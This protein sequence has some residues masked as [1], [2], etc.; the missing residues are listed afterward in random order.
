MAERHLVVRHEINWRNL[1]HP[2]AAIC[3]ALAPSGSFYI[4]NSAHGQLVQRAPTDFGILRRLNGH[5]MTVAD[6][7]VLSDE[8]AGSCSADGTTRV[9]DLTTGRQV[10]AIRH[11]AG[12]TLVRR[13]SE[14]RGL[15][16]LSDGSA[17]VWEAGTGNLVW[18]R[19]ICQGLPTGAATVEG[20]SAG[21]IL[22][23]RGEIVRVNLDNGE[24][25]VVRRPAP[26]VMETAAALAANRT[27]QRLAYCIRTSE[28]VLERVITTSGE[29]VAELTLGNDLCRCSIW[30]NNKDFALGLDDGTVIVVGLDEEQGLRRV[31]ER[32]VHRNIVWTIDYAV[33]A[34]ELITGSSDGTVIRVSVEGLREKA[35]F[36][37]LTRGVWTTAWHPNGNRLLSAAGDG[38]VALWDVTSSERLAHAQLAGGWIRFVSWT[39][40]SEAIAVAQ[41]GVVYAINTDLQENAVIELELLGNIW[42]ADFDRKKERLCFGTDRGEVGVLELV[43]GTTSFMRL[44]DRL[45]SAVSWKSDGAIIVGTATGEGFELTEEGDGSWSA[46]VIQALDGQDEITAIMTMPDL[47]VALGFFSGRISILNVDGSLS[48]YGRHDGPVQA[49]T[50]VQGMLASCGADGDVNVWDREGQSRLSRHSVLV[51]AAGLSISGRQVALGSGGVWVFD[52]QFSSETPGDESVS[53]SDPPLGLVDAPVREDTIGRKGLV[54]EL[55]FLCRRTSDELVRHADA[56]PLEERGFLIHIGGEWGAGKTSLAQMVLDQLADDQRG[57]SWVSGSFNAWQHEQSS[58]LTGLLAE[59]DRCSVA[60]KPVLSRLWGVLRRFWITRPGLAR[61]VIACIV[62][63]AVVGYALRAFLNL[64]IVAPAHSTHGGLTFDADHLAALLT[65]GGAVLAVGSF[66]IGRARLLISGI[67][68]DELNSEAN[69]VSSYQHSVLRRM[70]KRAVLVVDEVDRC[71]PERVVE[72]LRACNQLMLARPTRSGRQRRGRDSH[73]YTLAFILLSEREWLYNAIESSYPSQLATW[74]SNTKRLGSYFMEKLALV[75]FDL[76]TLSNSARAAIVGSATGEDAVTMKTPGF[77]VAIGFE[78]SLRHTGRGTQAGDG[79]VSEIEAAAAGAGDQEDNVVNAG[80]LRP[81]LS[82]TGDPKNRELVER[83]AE[84]ERRMRLERK[85]IAQYSSL[86]GRNP[87][88]IKRVLVRYWLDRVMAAAETREVNQFAETILFESIVT[89]RW[90]NLYPAI[91]RRRVGGVR[92]LLDQL[93]GDNDEDLHILIAVLDHAWQKERKKSIDKSVVRGKQD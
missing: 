40:P 49:F 14:K 21:Y 85:Y 13:V 71:E 86:I 76:P 63:L 67:T 27:A 53:L 50:V 91:T 65:V 59:L 57:Q 80:T 30:L 52:L 74:H 9:W 47:R 58:P 24:A 7:A 25:E 23:E 32:A 11:A 42:T 56:G 18:Q 20:A 75:S 73:H 36:D 81:V 69:R 61:T 87:R 45:V 79:P 38:T 41:K 54:D 37:G 77:E 84:V 1:I 83:A 51:S 5:R 72:I 55:A 70:P 28:G 8:A 60:S 10:A 92:E 35:S 66:L 17:C 34:G 44:R 33:E 88:E 6:V 26:D 39:S 64:L 31:A 68:K 62:V 46:L 48:P 12:A 3:A 43:T 78:S 15:T 89:I 22:T 16:V 19:Q 4:V 82:S 2:G 90:P 29:L 93:G